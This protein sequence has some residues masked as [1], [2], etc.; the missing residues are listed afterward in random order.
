VTFPLFAKID[1]NGEQRPSAV[2]APEKSAP[3]LLGTEGIKWNFT[4]FLVGRTAPSTT[5]TR[6]HQARRADRRH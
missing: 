2:K 5:A 3:G 6:R 4:K 1:V